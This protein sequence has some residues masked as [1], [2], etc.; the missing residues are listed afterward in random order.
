MNSLEQ[1]IHCLWFRGWLICKEY[2]WV[3]SLCRKVGI[4]MYH[5]TCRHSAKWQFSTSQTFLKLSCMSQLH[6]WNWK[7][8]QIG[9]KGLERQRES[10][11][12]WTWPLNYLNPASEILVGNFIWWNLQCAGEHQVDL[13]SQRWLCGLNVVSSQLNPD[14]SKAT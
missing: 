8:A 7:W 2:V 12:L 11:E 5:Y 1:K 3:T 14:S 10:T 4:Y 6:P 9:L 13:W